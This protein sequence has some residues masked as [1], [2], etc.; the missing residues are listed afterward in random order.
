MHTGDH[1]AFEPHL[2]QVQNHAIAPAHTRPQ[3]CRQKPIVTPPDG[4]GHIELAAGEDL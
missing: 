2:N 1:P 4:E 3:T